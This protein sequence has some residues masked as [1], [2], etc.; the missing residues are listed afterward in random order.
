[1][2]TIKYSDC[3][4]TVTVEREGKSQTQVNIKTNQ[5]SKIAR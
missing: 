2:K 1:M 3:T 5:K 4:S